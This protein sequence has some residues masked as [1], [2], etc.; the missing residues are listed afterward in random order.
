MQNR[1]HRDV[2]CLPF[3]EFEFQRIVAVPARQQ[4]AHRRADLAGLQIQADDRT[5]HRRQQ[6]GPGTLQ[7]QQRVQFCLAGGGFRL[8]DRRRCT[9]Q[10]VLFG[11]LF[12]LFFQGMQG[13]VAGI[14]HALGS[15]QRG[16]VGRLGRFLCLVQ[17]FVGSFQRGGG[18]FYLRLL[19]RLGLIARQSG[20]QRGVARGFHRLGCF[21]A[22]LARAVHFFLPVRPGVLR[23][24]VGALQLLLGQLGGI[25]VGC[26]AFCL[27]RGLGLQLLQL[28]AFG[29]NGPAQ[30]CFVKRRQ[31][32]TGRY[33]LALLHRHPGDE[34]PR[35]HRERRTAGIA[36]RTRGLYALAD[37]AGR[38]GLYRDHRHR[39]AGR[40]PRH[41]CKHQQHSKKACDA[42]RTPMLLRV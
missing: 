1:A 41:Q 16:L 32:V 12:L 37:A 34:Q 3:V 4:A 7:C 20:V 15:R 6:T 13:G 21:A 38:R 2:L 28:R 5:G 18:G 33:L 19:L 35:R 25:R 22:F 31:H 23:V 10:R 30:F 40:P 26:I 17:R 42:A 27:L 11:H 8:A 36:D 24:L 39:G 9:V 14:L 29:I